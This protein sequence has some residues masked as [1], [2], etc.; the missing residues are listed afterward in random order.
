M[1]RHQVGFVAQPETQERGVYPRYF[2]VTK[3]KQE[4]RGVLFC[5]PMTREKKFRAIC[6]SFGVEKTGLRYVFFLLLSREKHI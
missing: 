1:V 6:F 5:F 2:H 4:K 3:T